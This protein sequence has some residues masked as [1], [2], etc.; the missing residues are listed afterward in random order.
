MTE[1]HSTGRRKFLGLGLF[2]AIL[3][4]G[5]C[6][7]SDAPTEVTEPKQGGNRKRLDGLK[8]KAPTVKQKKK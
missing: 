7:D 3:I 6:G 5:G 2:G 4:V 8:D 1:I